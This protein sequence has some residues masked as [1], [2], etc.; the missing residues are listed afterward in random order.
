[1]EETKEN[2]IFDDLG[3]RSEDNISCSAINQIGYGE[4]SNLQLEVFGNSHLLFFLE[5]I[6]FLNY[7]ASNLHNKST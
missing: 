5:L 3:V 7:S 2:L 6:S 1:M 4:S